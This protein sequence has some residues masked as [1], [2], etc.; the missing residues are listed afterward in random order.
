MGLPIL[1]GTVYNQTDSYKDG[2]WTRRTG[3]PVLWESIHIR[4]L[5]LS[6]SMKRMFLCEFTNTGTVCSYGKR[7]NQRVIIKE[8][9]LS[10]RLW[11][12]CWMWFTTFK[13]VLIAGSVYVLEWLW[14]RGWGLPPFLRSHICIL[15]SIKHLIIK[16]GL[17]SLKLLCYLY[18][19]TFIFTKDNI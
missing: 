15:F 19:S 9:Y 10:V 12:G 6:V 1:V 2:L 3:L 16:V 4:D 18:S 14:T 11:G 5:Y 8:L 17:K 13:N 7:Y